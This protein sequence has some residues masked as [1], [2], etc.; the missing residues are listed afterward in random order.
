MATNVSFNPNTKEPAVRKLP[1]PGSTTA[2]ARIDS[3]GRIVGNR[4]D[5]L[6]P[7]GTQKPDG[8]FTGDFRGLGVVNPWGGKH[9][10]MNKK[11]RR[12]KTR[13]NKTRRNKT[14][15]RR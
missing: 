11:T 4:K 5:G 8:T 1:Y 6:Q 12:N 10:K 3:V 9:K 14:R 7:Y 15:S 13:R 2:P